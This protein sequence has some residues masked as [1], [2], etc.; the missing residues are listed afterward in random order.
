MEMREAYV[1]AEAYLNKNIKAPPDDSY[2]I[3]ESAIRESELGWYFPYQTARFIA[4]RDIEYSV[5]GNWPIFVAKTGEVIGP[6][7]PDQAL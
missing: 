1:L 7:R 5:V 3:V 2:V 6:R 4:T